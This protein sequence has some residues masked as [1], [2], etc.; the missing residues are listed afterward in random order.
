MM[1]SFMQATSVLLI[2][3]GSSVFGTFLLLLHTEDVPKALSESNTYNKLMIKEF[4]NE[5]RNA[6][7]KSVKLR[8]S[9]ISK[10][11]FTLNYLN[12]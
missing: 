7:T 3:Q 2:P 4:F 11:W 6:E 8:T 10:T 12:W 9:G 1:F 5:S